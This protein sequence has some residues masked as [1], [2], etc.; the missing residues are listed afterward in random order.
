MVSGGVKIRNLLRLSAQGRALTV[1]PLAQQG[2][3]LSWSDDL[4][5]GQIFE[6][7]KFVF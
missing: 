6:L 2:V 3:G 7:S 5:F 1:S 4:G